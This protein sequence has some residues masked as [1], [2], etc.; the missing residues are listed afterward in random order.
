MQR[1][2][3]GGALDRGGVLAATAALDEAARLAADADQI[4]AESQ[5]AHR[6]H[7]SNESK[8]RDDHGRLTRLVPERRRLM[9]ELSK[10]YAP[11]ALE[12]DPD[13]DGPAAPVS[14]AGNLRRA[15]EFLQG[16]AAATA[17]AAA[18]HGAGR[19]LEGAAHHARAWDLHGE[20]EAQ[21]A[22]I[23]HHAEALKAQ[24]NANA[25]T[26]ASLGDR[27]EAAGRAAE[28]PTT[29][30]NSQRLC[31]RAAGAFAEAAAAARLEPPDLSDPFR[32]A[33]LLAGADEALGKA[34]SSMANDREWFAEAS[35]SHEHAAAEIGIAKQLCAQARTDSIPDSPATSQAIAEVNDL[36]R[37]LEEHAADLRR[38]H[39]D[40]VALDEAIDRT[41]LDAAR[42]AATLRGELRSANEALKAIDAAS[43]RVREA[44]GWISLGIADHGTSKLD[45]ARRQLLAGDYGEALQYAEAARRAASDAI[46]RAEAAERRRRREREEAERRRRQQ[47]RSSFSSSSSSRSRSSSFGSRS[48]SSSSRS[49]SSRGS[50]FSRS[51]W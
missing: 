34:E 35:Q 30:A 7:A 36:A 16:G 32:A 49:S 51:G 6:D 37:R 33:A 15:D 39:G 22:A 31:E 26:L 40:W 3:A 41:A 4:V 13:G 38:P 24:E 17:E 1:E 10:R 46:A 12:F 27:L 29:M 47:S 19:L 44:T 2:A 21:L 50:G 28:E 48:R 45:V 5:E 9:E 25:A 42:H 14:L 20:A 8:L 23:P 11:A 18:A 43:R